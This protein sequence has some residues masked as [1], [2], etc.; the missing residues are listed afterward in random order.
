M[1]SIELSPLFALVK[2]PGLI[3][4]SCISVV[5]SLILPKSIPACVSPCQNRAIPS[6]M[7]KSIFAIVFIK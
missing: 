6:Q 5:S 2:F 1:M 7:I 3:E 4:A